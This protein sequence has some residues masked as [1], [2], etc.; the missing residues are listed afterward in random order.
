[1]KQEEKIVWTIGHST[2]PI[3]K[4]ISILQSFN[5]ELIADVRTFPGSRKYPQFNKENLE[6]SLPSSSIRYIHLPQLGGRRKARIESKNTGWKN[7]AFRGYA[8]YMDT[9]DFAN[10][11]TALEH[12]AMQK[13]V[14]YMCSESVWWKCHRRLIS[15]YLKMR[16]WKVVHIMGENKGSEHVLTSPAHLV[17]G[18]LTYEEQQT[19]F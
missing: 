18:Q 6:V 13:R 7:A 4:F 12:L 5:I 2:H 3:E 16:E 15:D 17:H 14:A 8:D 10:G 19:L 11:I 1:M 9:E